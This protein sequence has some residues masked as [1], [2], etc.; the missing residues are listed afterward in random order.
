MG[1]RSYRCPR[2]EYLALRMRHGRLNDGGMN[3]ELVFMRLNLMK[4][5][6]PLDTL[7]LPPE[8][9]VFGHSPAMRSVRQLVDKVAATN[10]PVLIQGE[11][12]TGKDVMARYIH[13]Q[14]ASCSQAFVKVNCAA[15]PGTLLES[16]LFGYEKGAFTGAYT[17]KPGR[18]EKS[19]GGTLFLD[20]IGEMEASLQVKMLQLLQ[21]GSFCRIGDHEEKRVETRVICATSR[22]LEREAQEGNFRP[23]LF[24][25]IN[26][27]QIRMP[28]LRDR[29]EDV[30]LLANYLL[31]YYC[32]RFQRSA[33][34]FARELEQWFEN[35]RWS[36]NIRELGNLVAR[37]VLLGAE[38]AIACEPL[39]GASIR[40]KIQP[41]ESG[42]IPLKHI[43]KEAVRELERNVIL[44]VLQANAWNRRKAAQIL[45]IS[46]RGL[47][48][49]IREAGLAQRNGRGRSVAP[50]RPK[51]SGMGENP[52]DT[53]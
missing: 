10:I 23:D 30:L 29:R 5:R 15:I 4:T 28:S 21:D 34:P 44:K 27:I 16:E 19:H 17:S 43:A 41:A 50:V 42:R 2:T 35:H 7:N 12:G 26:V 33:P 46:Y 38:E 39:D 9:I 8:D 52:L 31:G 6:T 25:R 14:S 18:V 24:Y 45:N 51:A 1:R 20:E 22:N 36:G 32:Q 40:A 37:Y 53:I 3:A 47:M 13:S 11:C 48:K 49:K